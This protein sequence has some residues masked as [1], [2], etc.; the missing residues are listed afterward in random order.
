MAIIG[1]RL[2]H[3][4]VGEFDVTGIA[5]ET[6]REVADDDVSG[7]SAEMAYHAI[8]AI[9]PFLLLLAG[10]T[11]I[12]DNVFSVG[13]LTD[14]IVDKAAQ[15]MPEDAVSVIRS[16][17][18]E[19]V[20]ADGGI[21]IVV[22]LV[23]SLW[24]ASSVIGSAMKALNRAYDVKE[25]RGL[26]RRKL[27][28]L[29]LTFVFGGLMLAAAMLVATGGII[30]GGVGEAVGWESQFVRLWNWVTLPAALMLVVLAVALL[31]WL[32]PNTGHQFRWITP[33]AA[34]FAIGWVIASLAF[35]FYVANF[36]SYNRTYGSIGAVI[37]LLVWLYW[38][39]FLLLVGGELNAVLA[40][41]HDE[42]YQ[43]ESGSQ[44]RSGSRAQP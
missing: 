20:N 39:N 18:Q 5:R 19:V 25:D 40:R 8:L 21:A 16:F 12:V 36:A 28:A 41:R 7:L 22:G 9:F 31:Y 13:N 26:V 29:A 42:E 24:A 32:A 44:P 37:I 2:Q 33:G 14:R 30:A 34:L 23:G 4:R 17:T 27:I 38:T 11:S 15:V 6:A 35:A 1:E 43:R 10:L 3:L